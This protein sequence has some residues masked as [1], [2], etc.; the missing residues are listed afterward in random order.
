MRDTSYL[1]VK[2]FPTHV[3]AVNLSLD[4]IVRTQIPN[5]KHLVFFMR[6]YNNDRQTTYFVTCFPL[7][8]GIYTGL[9]QTNAACHLCAC[10]V[11]T[12]DRSVLFVCLFVVFFFVIFVSLHKQGYAPVDVKELV[13]CMLHLGGYI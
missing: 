2:S 1:H 12:L 6:M 10:I 3:W 9:P 4:A 5:L 8:Q 13:H 11:K 7:H